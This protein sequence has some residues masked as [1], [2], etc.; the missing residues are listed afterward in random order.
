VYVDDRTIDSHIK[1]LRINVRARNIPATSELGKFANATR[2]PKRNL[3]SAKVFELPARIR[4]DRAA[5][6]LREGALSVLNG[7]HHD[8]GDAAL[9][10]AARDLVG[11]VAALV[12]HVEGRQRMLDL[13]ALK[14]PRVSARL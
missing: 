13:L 11:S 7:I 3:M 2:N 1:R 4:C 14:R 9:H 12:A 8:G 10:R 6:E 5:R